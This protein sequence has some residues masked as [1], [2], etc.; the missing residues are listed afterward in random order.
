MMS[1]CL[2]SMLSTFAANEA[3][4]ARY[5]AAADL[6]K[7]GNPDQAFL[8]Y[9]AIPGV[10]HVAIHH[11]RKDPK[12]Y[13]ELLEKN[14]EH[15]PQPLRLAL[16]ADLHLALGD[17]K[18][19]RKAFD[20]IA[21]TFATGEETWEQGFIPRYD[22]LREHPP[23]QEDGSFRAG[24][25]GASQFGWFGRGP[26]SHR[27]NWLIRRA[28]AFGRSDVAEREYLRVWEIHRLRA[29]AHVV[30][31]TVYENGKSA[32]VTR[33]VPKGGFD[34]HALQFTLDFAF[35]LLREEKNDEAF[36]LLS[37]A[38][39]RIDMDRDPNHRIPVAASGAEM[40]GLLQ[41]GDS[42]MGRY[43]RSS[44]YQ[45]AGVSRKEFI[46]LAYGAFAQ[47]G[48]PAEIEETITSAIKA[49][50]NAK[51]R[52]LARLRFHQNRTDEALELERR[53]LEEGE[54]NELNCHYRYGLV[55]EDAGRMEDA[56][57]HY[58]EARKH[59]QQKPRLPDPEET[60]GAE[61]RMPSFVPTPQARSSKSH[62][63]QDTAERLVRL[64]RSTGNSDK[65]YETSITALSA[66]PDRLMEHQ[67]IESLLLMADLAGKKDHCRK[68]LRELANKSPKHAATILWALE[69]YEGCTKALAVSRH[70]N[71]EDDLSSN[72]TFDYWRDRF[73]AID[74]AT[75]LIYA[76][77]ILAEQPKNFRPRLAK[78]ELTGTVGDD[79][80][81]A[82]LEEIIE[83]NP[84]FVFD[85]NYQK[86]P[87]TRF[88]NRIDPG[89]RLL[90]IYQHRGEQKKFQKLALRIAA[91]EQPFG[92][93]WVTPR[94]TYSLDTNGWA[95]NVASCLSLIIDQ[96][97]QETLGKLTELWKDR[98]DLPPVR[99]LKRRLSGGI[100]AGKAPADIGWANLAEGVRL[101]VSHENVICM[102]RDSQ[103]LY[104][105]MPWGVLVMDHSGDPVTRFLLGSGVS[106]MVARE[107]VL[108]AGTGR[109]LFRIQSD[110]W[111]VRRIEI[112][113]VVTEEEYPGV[114]GGKEEPAELW[115]A[116]TVEV[117][118]MEGEELWI[119]CNNNL[120]RINTRTMER[121]VWSNRELGYGGTN[122]DIERILFMDGRVFIE[123]YYGLSRYEP[124]SETFSPITYHGRRVKLIHGVDDYLLGMAWLDEQ[125][126]ERVCV[127]DPESLELRIIRV[128]SGPDDRP[129]M[130]SDGTSLL[131]MHNGRFVLGKGW[132]QEFL[133]H[134]DEE[135][136]VALNHE[137]RIENSKIRMILPNSSGLGE[138]FGTRPLRSSRLMH[139][140]PFEDPVALEGGRITTVSLPDGGYLEY[141]KGHSESGW[142]F[143]GP[144]SSQPY[145][146]RALWR[147]SDTGERTLLT[148]DGAGD[149]ISSD[150]VISVVPDGA[151][152]ER[153]LCTTGGISRL[154]A[155]NRVLATYSRRDGLIG[156]RILAGV[157]GNDHLHFAS[158]WSYRAGGLVCLDRKSGVFTALV[159]SDGLAS[160]KLAGISMEGDKLKLVYGIEEATGN[161]FNGYRFYA[162]S[163]IDPNAIRFHADHEP[164]KQHPVR[165]ALEK[166]RKYER[167]RK[168]DALL[169]ALIIDEQIIGTERFTMT[170][171][172]LAITAKDDELPALEFEKLETSLIIDQELVLERIADSKKL[173]AKTTEDALRLLD[174]ENPYQ[175]YRVMF[176]NGY[177][178]RTEL[179]G[180]VDAIIAQTRNRLPKAR[181]MAAELLG[182]M[183]DAKALPA[184][185]KLLEDEDGKVMQSAALAMGRLRAPADIGVYRQMLK[186]RSDSTTKER[187]CDAL[188]DVP[189]PEVMKLLL[190]YPMT[191]DNYEDRQKIFAR[192]GAT[193]RTHPELTDVFLK[194]Q[195]LDQDIGPRANWG[196]TRFAQEVLSHAGEGLLITLHKKLQSENRIVRANAA[197]ACG[198]IGSTSS[199]HPLLA[200]LD[201]ESGLSRGA[202]VWAIGELKATEAL[203]TLIKIY[204][205]ATNDAKRHSHTGYRFMQMSGHE[206]ARFESMSNLASL[207][208][209]FD[210]LER[211]PQKQVYDPRKSEFLLTPGVVIEAVGKIGNADAF[212]RSLAGEKD[213]G[214]RQEAAIQ[215]V[216][217]PGSQCDETNRILVA[218]LAD[219]RQE[220]RL[221]AAVSLIILGQD[222]GQK[223]VLAWLTFK[224]AQNH[225]QVIQ[226]L[227][228]V[229]DGAK[230]TF[231][232]SMLQQI[233]TNVKGA[234]TY[235]DERLAELINR[236]P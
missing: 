232:K 66:N 223:R 215:L 142:P 219:P 205:D 103:Y 109:G 73:A 114:N 189:S 14:G 49:G 180:L 131:G 173:Y 195:N 44:P 58:E 88:S 32:Q 8:A 11:G 236:I 41:L 85:Q 52:L 144:R 38:M 235:T 19:A 84:G 148:E 140:S 161:P 59:L 54:F 74:Q 55:L 187:V 168:R 23:I 196:R 224:D 15:V 18:S 108:W 129:Y 43:S 111:S 2:W 121:R 20:E 217:N 154:D 60:V 51:R 9:A 151:T 159:K 130:G 97:D 12:H 39:M 29:N 182:H 202:I 226:E 106:A 188:A 221:T 83:R 27:D 128:A 177:R 16:M 216:K 77:A 222:L 6:L 200:A 57:T 48:R 7:K 67:A 80:H 158:G 193:V 65:S 146:Q 45:S 1:L 147:V 53:F 70:L 92:Q 153:W 115:E 207:K 71:L 46:R 137:S 13:L 197:R 145:G 100:A 93:W 105:G 209:D 162:P 167:D 225:W 35:F 171:L 82:L 50:D 178:I 5:N 72:N 212:Y 122:P 157:A 164:V 166:K 76:D 163:L 198:A 227:D 91:G 101:L 47:S 116:G 141:A 87:R 208:A 113:G 42:G 107:G 165:T 192:L 203:P 228:R 124:D 56:I 99:Q 185:K 126:R 68:R 179:D 152:G 194:A 210:E 206:Q 199:I 150:A 98:G 186:G 79:T 190:D 95:E 24:F 211:S 64:Y 132:Q 160:N 40:Q 133:W 218:L 102:V 112:S 69:D 34:A 62:L 233:Q 81:Q 220:V 21:T 118:A 125:R 214:H 4:H 30:N 234:N 184:L 127:I 75:E 96:A 175:Q 31:L 3:L 78:W 63:D 17:E 172:G 176:R 191:A 156:D 61:D 136:M 134:P 36:R 230:L 104:A 155:T 117:L 229:K 201:L 231:I 174:T 170:T 204:T 25:M 183:G 28:I 181:E 213:S 89:Y 37:E 94:D 135:S 123:D 120:Q 86:Y 90:R 119:G 149:L 139:E 26:G 110:D 143:P 138:V 10:H 22:Y 33:L 169:Q